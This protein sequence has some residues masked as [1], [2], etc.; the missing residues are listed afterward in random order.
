ME[1][2]DNYIKYTFKSDWDKDMMLALLMKLPFESF[3]ETDTGLIGYLSSGIVDDSVD[4]EIKIFAESYKIIVHREI[5]ENR[6]WNQDWE[7]SFKP[8]AID[9]FCI[10]K[11][12]F[13]NV[14]TSDYKYSIT[15]NPKM[16]FGTGHHETTVMMIRL[17][18]SINLSGQTV[19]DFGSG[20]GIL[21]I[22]AEMMGAKEIIAI[23]NDP[24]AVINIEENTSLN[25]CSC[26]KAVLS[27]KPEAEKYSIDLVLANIDRNVL[28]TNVENISGVLRKGGIL[29]LSGILISDQKNIVDTYERHSL[30]L[31]KSIKERGWT[32]MKFI[33]Y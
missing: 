20:T 22:L 31:M 15:I 21:A 1:T 25:K 19:M 32:A 24:E 13:H 10:V 33:A 11:S 9:D 18:S 2:P 16:T 27:E 17:M 29:L 3:E 8:V 30:K 23:D 26:I 6:N 7:E 14:E 4:S 5:V 28:I 12:D